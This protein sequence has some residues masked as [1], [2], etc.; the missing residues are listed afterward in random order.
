MLK[1][2]TSTLAAVALAATAAVGEAGTVGVDGGTSAPSSTLGGYTMTV[3]PKGVCVPDQN[4]NCGIVT[5]VASPLGGQVDFDWSFSW[6]FSAGTPPAPESGS[7]M[8]HTQIAMGW[9]GWSNGYTGDVYYPTQDDAPNGLTQGATATANV[10]VTFT[11]PAD[12]VAFY[13]YVEPEDW[14]LFDFTATS[15]GVSVTATDVDGENGANYFGFYGTGGS[16][17]S[18]ITVSSNVRF[19]VGQ[20]GIASSTAVVPLPAAAWSGLGL[21]GVLALVRRRRRS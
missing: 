5:S 19:A 16:T 14:E 7:D 21:L 18:S 3:F 13:F 8:C 20:F 2:L 9:G 12:T 6:D 15:N 10:A 17:I 11:L 1:F 4:G